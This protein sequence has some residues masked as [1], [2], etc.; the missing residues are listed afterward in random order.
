VTEDIVYIVSLEHYIYARDRATGN[1]IWTKPLGSASAGTPAIL[2]GALYVSLFGKELRALDAK[3]GETLWSFPTTGWVW[4]GPVVKDTIVYFSDMEGTVY[5]VDTE[6]HEKVWAVTPGGELRGSPVILG[7]FLYV[8]DTK[9]EIYALQLTDGA[10][11]HWTK[12]TNRGQLLTSPVA[13]A[14]KEVI[15][16]SG[17]QGANLLEGYTPSGDPKWPPFAPSK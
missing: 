4:G 8:G 9:G 15:V 5:A 1:E 17:Y 6:T 10:I 3:T 13:V 7:E 2:D 16:F 12:G 14:A 11:K